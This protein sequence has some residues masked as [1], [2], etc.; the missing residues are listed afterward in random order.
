MHRQTSIFDILPPI[1]DIPQVTHVYDASWDNK[2]VAHE[3]CDS[4]SSD[5]TSET[6][7]SIATG[8]REQNTEGIEVAHEQCDQSSNSV[9]IETATVLNTQLTHQN[10]ISSNSSNKQPK[11][12]HKINQ[13]VEPYYVVRAGKKYRYHRYCWMSSGSRK[14]HRT[15]IGSVSSKAAIEKRANVLQM[16]VDDIAPEEIIRYL[17]QEKEN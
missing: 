12:P 4:N 1:P 3:Q 16:I 9:A 8:V 7:Q 11:P 14:Q 13:W 2:T 17:K 10:S 15:H 6:P 5:V